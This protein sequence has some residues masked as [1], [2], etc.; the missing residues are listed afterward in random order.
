MKN[1]NIPDYHQKQSANI[2][3]RSQNRPRHLPFLKGGTLGC[4]KIQSIIRIHDHL[5]CTLFPPI[6]TS[7]LDPFFIPACCCR[8]FLLFLFFLFLSCCRPC[9]RC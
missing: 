6:C 9:D 1:N 5:H 3:T 2:Q 4:F 7:V 8:F